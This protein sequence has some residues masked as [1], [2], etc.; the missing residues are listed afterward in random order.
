VISLIQAILYAQI[1]GRDENEKSF[2]ILQWLLFS[3]CLASGDGTKTLND[4]DSDLSIPGL[5]EKA[6]HIAQ[7]GASHVLKHS[8]PPRWQLRCVSANVASV[9][10]MMLLSIDEETDGS[11]LLFNLKS[12]QSRC[13]DMSRK[14]NITYGVELHS[15]PIFHLQ[16]LVKTA[17]GTSTATSNHSELPSVQISGLSLLVSIFRSFSS[18]L[19]ASTNDGT[20]VLEQYSSQ[21]VS[22]V[23]HALNSESLL[24]ESVPGTAFFRLFSAG[25]EALFV[26]ISEELISDPIAMRRLLQP[27][28][29]SAEETPFVQF[30]MGDRNE[31][32]TLL[33]SSTHVT[34]DSRSYPLFRL[35]KLCFLSKVSMLIALGD[36]SIQQSTVSIV[37]G[38]LEKEEMGRAIHCAAA[39]ID[40]FLLQDSQQ[41]QS[42]SATSG[43]T[44]KNTTDLDES[45]I[46]TLIENWPTLGA[47]AVSSIIKAIKAAGNGSA[48]MRS[49]QQWLTK[50]TPVIVTGLRHSLS[51]LHLG[52]KKSS[53]EQSSASET[54]ALCVYAVRLCVR[55]NEHVGEGLSSI[56]LGDIANIVTECVIFHVL[57]LSDSEDGSKHHT[58]SRLSLSKDHKVLVQQSCGLIEDLCQQYC[59][60]GVDA[61]ILTRAV[62]LPLVTMQE[63]RAM[64]LNHGII[65]SSCIRS[66]QSLLQSHPEDGRA[67]FEKALVQLVLTLLK[68]SSGPEEEIK[69]ACLP[70]L[71]VCCEKTTMSH[72]EWGKI[73]N[74]SATYGL[75]DAWAIVCM[76]LPPGYGIK[77][78]IDAIKMS[79][80]DIQSVPR[81]AAALVALRTALHSASVEDPSLLCFVLQSVGF[82]ILQ[83]LR[84]HGVRIIAG[85]GF[86]ENRVTVCAES[87]K[88]NIMAFQYL[89]S[90]SKEDSK[91]VSFISAMFEVL[92]EI[93]SFNGMPNH[94]SG[95]E[96]A[97]ETIG[98][99]CSQVFVHVARTAPMMFKSTMAIISPE[100][101][102]V[103]EAAVRADM[104]GY[105]A[106]K[107]ETKKKISLKGFVR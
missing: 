28:L 27:V 49:L 61:S 73:A 37:A 31:K 68:D 100:N 90:V 89:N 14:E 62:V 80:G 48:D 38:E 51:S 105:A 58:E 34:D 87:V 41:N 10:M 59:A 69:A 91:F 11:G 56:E 72:E 46:Q 52:D 76:T 39:A 17:C 84:G 83:L 8:N 71:R 57:G 82:E 93:I 103:L 7:V 107:R 64:E 99:M 13:I 3:R 104:S 86:D 79:L 97:D 81:H 77:C 63:N 78:S 33:M 74:Y 96:G 67:E 6:R 12:A 44:Y 5:I 9:A 60:I 45:V 16:E 22:S 66:S 23:K 65:I 106:P 50:L 42:S 19:D 53:P 4:A 92:V 21:I 35:S 36:I 40:G 85:E 47:S 30:P 18:Q 29:L 55:D 70:L 2:I 1:N 43:L 98:R 102:A 94:S 15:Q 24:S 26:M 25:C 101:R 95:K 20:S 32:G 88:V 54:A 75:W